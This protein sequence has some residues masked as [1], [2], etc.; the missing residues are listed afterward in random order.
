MIVTPNA[1]NVSEPV[2]AVAGTVMVSDVAVGAVTVAATAPIRTTLL[3]A[4]VEKPVPVITIV[5][6]IAAVVREIVVIVGAA[7]TV[8]LVALARVRPAKVTEILPVV[9]PALALSAP[10]NADWHGSCSMSIA[11]TGTCGPALQIAGA[12]SATAL[13]FA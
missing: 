3:A 5:A 8:R 4:V 6:P 13:K 1:V 12:A 7:T 10:M 11:I 2:T 9:A